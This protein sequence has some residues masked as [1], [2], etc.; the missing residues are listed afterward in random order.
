MSCMC[1]VGPGWPHIP[2]RLYVF[3]RFLTPPKGVWEGPRAMVHLPWNTRCRFLFPPPCAFLAS[4]PR[5]WEVRL[6]LGF[7]RR[8]FVSSRFIHFVCNLRCDRIRSPSPAKEGGSSCG[9]ARQETTC[10][11]MMTDPPTDDTE[12]RE[13][14]APDPTDAKHHAPLHGHT[15]G[16]PS[17]KALSDSAML[18]TLDGLVV[19]G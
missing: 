9:G 18:L 16:V 12:A 10:K 11:A 4:S 3:S 19:C 14:D 13:P 2:Y 1:M 7:A 6:T 17:D 8:R 5:A 15:G